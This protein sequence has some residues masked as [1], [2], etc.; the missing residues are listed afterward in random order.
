MGVSEAD[1]RF[2]EALV[3]VSGNGRLSDLY[4]RAPLPIIHRQI[5]EPEEWLEAAR[6][7]LEEHRAIVSAV[8]AGDVSGGQDILRTHLA[9]RYIVALQGG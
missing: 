9:K 5:L 6:K 8:L 4:Y 1:R 3:A 7:T 2:H